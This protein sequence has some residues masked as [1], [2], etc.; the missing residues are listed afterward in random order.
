[1]KLKILIGT[2]L[3]GMIAFAID[4]GA[5]LFQKAVT[6]ER[7]AGNLDDAIKMYQRVATEF[8]SDRALTAKALMAE[9][10]CYEK[11]G[12]DKATKL[13]QQVARDYRDQHDFAAAANA[14]LAAMQIRA[15]TMTQRK[16][17]LETGS[18]FVVY[19]TD[20]QRR[21]G[22]DNKA[23]ELIISD[24]SGANK[25]AFFK[26]KDS[27][28]KVNALLLSRDF[29]LALMSLKSP[30]ASETF[31]LVKTDGTGYRELPGDWSDAWNCNPEIAWDNRSVLLCRSVPHRPAEILQVSV[32]DGSVHKIAD[33]HGSQ[34]RFSPDGQYI[35]YR[36]PGGIYVMS[37]QVNGESQLV[38]GRGFVDDW[39]RDGRFLIVDSIDANAD[40]LYLIPV[41]YG[42]KQGPPILVRYGAFQP[43]NPFYEAG[44]TL[45]NGAFIYQST[46][47]GGQYA[48]W[49]GKLDSANGS[50]EWEKLTL[51]GGNAD[52]RIPTWSP[53]ST[54]FAYIANDNAA[55]QLQNG[56]LYLHNIASGD[57]RDLYHG[58]IDA[59][60][61]CLWSTQHAVLLCRHQADGAQHWLSVATDTGH[62]ETSVNAPPQ[63]EFR[64][65][66][67]ESLAARSNAGIFSMK[68]AAGGDWKAPLAPNGDWQDATSP[69]GKWRIFHGRDAAGKNG[70]FRVATTGGIPE[71]IGDF[72]GGN[73]RGALWVSPDS[74]KLIAAV[75]NP[76][77]LWMLENYEPKQ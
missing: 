31:A 72:P 46:P 25:R 9:A 24:L 23:G 67:R 34:Y 77:Q 63:E 26:L 74:Q 69:D 7:A 64:E 71:R 60:Q 15:V 10:R 59:G 20:G 8:A 4:N 39:T 55:G 17:D 16:I 57:D 21:A 54:Q 61:N 29:S 40:G 38:S 51:A 65:Y 47:P 6:T 19:H 58:D 41:A 48:T 11:L 70:L 66:G 53:D 43:Y 28:R 52:M 37:S 62:A 44:R 56:V 35:A 27:V 45:A 73:I 50:V 75:L 68:P 22:W 5:E 76:L 3:F 30:D 32:A 1:M 49:L 36:G 13:Y 14:R 18:A 12:Q 33:M 42:I 2:L